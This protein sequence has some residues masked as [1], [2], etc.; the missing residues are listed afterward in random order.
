[1]AL[2]EY[3]LHTNRKTCCCKKSSG[4]EHKYKSSDI[5][6]LTGYG[7]IVKSHVKQAGIL[8]SVIVPPPQKVFVLDIFRLSVEVAAHFIN[9][10]DREAICRDIIEYVLCYHLSMRKNCCTI[11][12]AACAIWSG[13]VSPTMCVSFMTLVSAKAQVAFPL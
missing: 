12:T 10:V 5:L 1:V 9:S 6:T 2:A 4:N 8:A 7:M 13:V 3:T 11:W